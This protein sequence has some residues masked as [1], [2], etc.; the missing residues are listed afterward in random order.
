MCKLF[1]FFEVLRSIAGKTAVALWCLVLSENK[2]F[3]ETSRL[4]ATQLFLNFKSQ[5]PHEKQ[6]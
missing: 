1:R 5:I 6:T 4:T 3:I 2:T